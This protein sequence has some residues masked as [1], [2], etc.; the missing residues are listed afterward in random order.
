[1]DTVVLGLLIIFCIICVVCCI[2]FGTSVVTLNMLP[3]LECTEKHPECAKCVTEFEGDDYNKLLAQCT[4]H[5][6]A[7]EKEL[8]NMVDSLKK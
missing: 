1:M 5:C 2:G 3:L 6:S 4:P 7:C 8:Q